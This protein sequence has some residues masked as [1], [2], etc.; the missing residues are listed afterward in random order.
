MK[1]EKKDLWLGLK[2]LSP[3]P[4]KWF[5]LNMRDDMA[6]WMTPE[7]QMQFKHSLSQSPEE[8]RPKWLIPTAFR[9]V[10]GETPTPKTMATSAKNT[11]RRKRRGTYGDVETPTASSLAKSAS[12]A[13]ATPASQRGKG[14]STPMSAASPQTS[15]KGSA[16]TPSN[17]S[18][19]PE[20][21]KAKNENADQIGKTS[22]VDK[23]K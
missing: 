10:Q 9:N 18:T 6:F 19:I 23:S 2:L 8:R 4:E 11:N 5:W 20:S 13:K 17:I 21:E 12:T 15:R 1:S 16:S 14:S 7:E 22:A 3:G